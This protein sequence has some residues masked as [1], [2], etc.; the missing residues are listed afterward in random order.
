MTINDL[1]FFLVQ[2][3][4]DGLDAPVRCVLARMTTDTGLEGWGEAQIGWR[5]SELGARRELLLPTLAGQ[6]IFDIE[7]LI[8]LDVL[9]D[10]SL[11]CA[12]E[13]A[14]WDLIGRAVGE[15]LCHLFGGEY[16]KR[17]PVAVR[18][19]GKSPD[20][21]ARLARELADQGFHSQIVPSEGQMRQ[22]LETLGAVRETAGDRRELQFDAGASYDLDTARD[23]CMELEQSSVQC[24]FDPLATSELDQIASLKRQVNVPL[25]VRRA[26][27][28]PADVLTLLRCRAAQSLAVDLQQVGGMVLAR[29]CAVIAHAGEVS[30]SVSGGPSLGIG[31]AA[32]LQIAASTPAFSRANECAYHALQDD[33]L[34]EPLEIID[35][36]I[37]VPQ[38]PGLGVAVD[39]TKVEKYQVS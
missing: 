14:C 10:P 9:H 26:I 11:R 17:I 16:R 5:V 4:C 38:A 30:A 31:V 19:S 3:R 23:L 6:S 12:V 29:Q 37:A 35:G 13:M 21:I 36:M 25:A 28:S 7:E 2:V 22:D 24:V 27:R 34:V 39:R 15:P 18:L 20:E 33:L 8:S 32:M 1:E